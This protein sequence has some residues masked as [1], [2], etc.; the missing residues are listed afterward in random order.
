MESVLAVLHI[1]ANEMFGCGS[2]VW[3]FRYK[4]CAPGAIPLGAWESVDVLTEQGHQG[5]VS[6]LRLSSWAVF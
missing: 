5:G 6:E 3:T 2:G 4:D 1:P